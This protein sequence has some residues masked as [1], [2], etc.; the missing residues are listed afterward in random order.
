MAQRI[1]LLVRKNLKMSSGKIAA[2]CVHAALGLNEEA[3]KEY[4]YELYCLSPMLSVIVLQVSD[5][6]FKEAKQAMVQT[7]TPFY[8]V[9]D[10]GFTEIAA[11]TETV[12]AFMEED[13]RGK[14]VKNAE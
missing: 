6:K 10:A 8:V 7:Q 13:P 3:A 12:I 11:G 4:P 2:Q 1:K 9:A 14:E 5:A